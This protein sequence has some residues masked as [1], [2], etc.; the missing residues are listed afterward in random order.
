MRDNFNGESLGWHQNGFLSNG[1]SNY[2]FQHNSVYCVGGC[3][4]DIAFIPDDN[5]SNA[6]V[7]KNL[8]AATSYASYC[9]YPSSASSK[10]GTVTG[11]VV[12]DNVFQRGA[13]GKCAVYGPCTAGTRQTIRPVPTAMAMSG[14]VKLWDNGQPLGPP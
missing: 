12:T 10:P 9:L 13:N 7:E 14:R 11:M 4:S 8:L 5:I 2:T 6:T 3:T 1:G